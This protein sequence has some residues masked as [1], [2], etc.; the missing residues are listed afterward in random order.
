MG[1][2]ELKVRTD[3]GEPRWY[4]LRVRPQEEYTVAYMLR[5]QDVWTFVPTEERFR[6]RTRYVQQK[7]GFAHPEIPGCVFARFDGEPAWYYLMNN[8]LIL[9]VEG[10]D[11]KPYEFDPGQLFRFFA[12]SN[13]GCMVF[14][15]GLRM[16]HV[17]G[18]GLLRGPRTQVK[19]VSHRKRKTDDPVVVEPT[20]PKARILAQFRITTPEP[21]KAAA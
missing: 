14:D 4:A 11:G 9:G 19:V 15:K 2:H 8:Q 3:G 17:P 21:V 10:M 1:R 7:A 16:V 13:D 12:H 5:Q 18:K 20:G 6:R